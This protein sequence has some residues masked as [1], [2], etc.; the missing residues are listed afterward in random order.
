MH[1]LSEGECPSPVIFPQLLFEMWM[2]LR[3]AGV[4]LCEYASLM[5]IQVEQ[6]LA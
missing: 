4:D 6:S 3:N 5:V 1:W 2:K